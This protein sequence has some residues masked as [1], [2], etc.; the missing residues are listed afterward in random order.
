MCMCVCVYECVYVWVYEC[1]VYVCVCVYEC[2]VYVWVYECALYVCMCV[3]CMCVGCV[4]VRGHVVVSAE[5]E[6][7]LHLLIMVM[8]GWLS[9]GIG[10]GTGHQVTDTNTITQ[11]TFGHFNFRLVA[12]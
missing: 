3:L 10:E 6:K 1:A 8:L 7:D 5:Q 9:S 12:S 4:C 11:T 2:A